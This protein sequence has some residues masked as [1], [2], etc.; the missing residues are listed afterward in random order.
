MKYG[1]FNDY[2]GGGRFS[3]RITA[4]FVM[5]GAVARKL[6]AGIGI[7]IVAH[8]VEIGG[9]TAKAGDFR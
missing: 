4:G 3:G 9:I 8:T 6:L 5:A 2:R 7:E 1:G